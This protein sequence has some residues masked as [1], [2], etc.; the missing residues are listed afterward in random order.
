MPYIKNHRKI[1]KGSTETTQ[2]NKFSQVWNQY[3]S[4]P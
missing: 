1:M 2:D 4:D 3:I